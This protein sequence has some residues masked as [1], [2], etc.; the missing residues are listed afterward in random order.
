MEGFC[1]SISFF[2]FPS[3]EEIAFYNGNRR[4]K[5][6]IHST[7]KKLV[8]HSRTRTA[9]VHLQLRTSLR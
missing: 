1:S 5:Q 2:I 9:V 3:S 7:F 8:G 4:E 6:T